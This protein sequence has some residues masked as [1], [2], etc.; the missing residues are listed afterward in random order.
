MW[1]VFSLHVQQRC[2]LAVSRQAKLFEN[3]AGVQ[4][5]NSPVGPLKLQLPDLT[6]D[7]DKGRITVLMENQQDG[8]SEQ[9]PHASAESSEESDQKDGASVLPTTGGKGMQ[10]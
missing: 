8:H 3:K 7:S 5:D 10:A 9:E 1:T 4:E 2:Q 6:R